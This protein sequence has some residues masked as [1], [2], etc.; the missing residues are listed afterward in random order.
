M[1]ATSIR[2]AIPAD[3]PAIASLNV[4]A[5]RWAYAGLVPDA[6]LDGLSVE[7]SEARCR[8][9]LA[10]PPAGMRTWVAERAGRVVGF[11]NVGPSRDDD[12]A[13]ETGEVYAIYVDP[14]D[15]GTG[16][17][18]AL[19]TYALERF[20]QQGCRTVTLWVLVGNQRACRFYEAA[21][22]VLDGATQVARY[23]GTPLDEM[24]YRFTLGD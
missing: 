16:A 23:D 18:Q 22:G 14:P 7:R 17:G 5:W 21:G 9:H 2:A 4:R 10:D 24:R 12:A 19:L 15:V 6:L 1:V 3:A 11:V 8:R 13:P 20:R